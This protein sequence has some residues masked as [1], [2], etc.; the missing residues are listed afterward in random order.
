MN[1][2]ALASPVRHAWRTREGPQ[3]AH[4]LRTFF[5]R[6]YLSRPSPASRAISTACARSTTCNLFN[7]FET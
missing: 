5:C 1:I 4:S 2:R 7:R 6:I 3:G